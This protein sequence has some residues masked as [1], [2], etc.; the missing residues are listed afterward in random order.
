MSERVL[1]EARPA[2]PITSQGGNSSAGASKDRSTQAMSER[3]LMEARPAQPITSQGGNSSASMYGL[4]L[5]LL[6][7]IPE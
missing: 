3:V 6:I 5:L 1:M 4:A 7:A 2:Q